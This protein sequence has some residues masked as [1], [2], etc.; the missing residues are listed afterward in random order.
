M[1]G[2]IDEQLTDLQKLQLEIINIMNE[3]QQKLELK[4]PNQPYKVYMDDLNKAF[5]KYLSTCKTLLIEIKEN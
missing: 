2:T 3:L 4:I 5:N 1:C